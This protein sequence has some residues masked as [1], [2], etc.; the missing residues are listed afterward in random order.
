MY[1]TNGNK[2]QQ[3]EHRAKITPIIVISSNMIRP[4]LTAVEPVSQP[5]TSP[6]S[7]KFRG[8]L[9]GEEKGRTHMLNQKRTG[10]TL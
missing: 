1:R 9:L 3:K 4:K 5:V 6:I 10:W 8:I 7:A 2:R